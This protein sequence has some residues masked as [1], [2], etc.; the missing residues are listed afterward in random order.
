MASGARSTALQPLAWLAGIL[1]VGLVFAPS[2]NAPSWVLG[3]FAGLLG[4]SV[5][6]FLC[7]YIYFALNQPDALR[8]EKFTLSKMAIEKNLIGDNR[9][10]LLEISEVEVATKAVALPNPKEGEPR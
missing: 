3:V 2:R 6:I 9:A 5:A 10:G 1:T 4:V 8:S 7:S